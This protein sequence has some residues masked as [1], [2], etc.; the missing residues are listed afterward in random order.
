MAPH[1]C[2]RLDRRVLGEFWFR[3]SLYGPWPPV[4]V[5]ASSGYRL[6][7][8]YPSEILLPNSM[9]EANALKQELTRGRRKVQGGSKG[10]AK[11]ET[12]H[13]SSLGI[14]LT[15][16][17]PTHSPQPPRDGSLSTRSDLV[18]VMVARF[19]NFEVGG[20]EDTRIKPG[21]VCV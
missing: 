20:R 18:T 13:S 16:P 2:I 12:N 11:V 17:H 9:S 7:L 8:S 1:A 4:L 5:L 15:P 3:G 19:L 14:V 6:P 10:K 21:D